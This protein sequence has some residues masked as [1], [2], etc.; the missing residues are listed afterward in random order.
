[1]EFYNTLK[2]LF[3]RWPSSIYRPLDQA[4]RQIR[5]LRILPASTADEVVSC[6]LKTVDFSPPLT[7]TRFYALS[8]VWGSPEAGKIILVD[9]LPLKVTANLWAMLWQLRHDPPQPTYGWPGKDEWLWADAICIN[10]NDIEER[11]Q[12]IKLFKDIYSN[13]TRV[14]AW[15]GLPDE[16]KIDV[17]LRST[18]FL[19][20]AIDV[21]DLD[22]LSEH[23]EYCQTD[24]GTQIGSNHY[25]EAIRAFADSDYWKRTWISQEVFLAGDRCL[26]FCGRE[27]LQHELLV[28]FA[29][30]LQRICERKGSRP[31]AFSPVVWD[32][33]TLAGRSFSWIDQYAT[34]QRTHDSKM[35]PGYP[36]DV[37]VWGR[38]SHDPRDAIYALLGIMDLDLV[39]DYAKSVADVYIDWHSRTWSSPGYSEIRFPPF[40]YLAGIGLLDD[41]RPHNI[42]SWIPN[43]SQLHR[44]ERLGVVM[45]AQFGPPFQFSRA[46]GLQAPSAPSKDTVF[47]CTGFSCGTVVS[48]SRTTDRQGS[49]APFSITGTLADMIYDC[50]VE[51][52]IHKFAR[53]ILRELTIPDHTDVRLSILGDE[54]RNHHPEFRRYID[55]PALANRLHESTLSVLHMG[56][57]LAE[58]LYENHWFELS[59]VHGGLNKLKYRAL[60]TTSNGFLGLGPKRLKV[61]DRLYVLDECKSLVLLRKIEKHWVLVGQCFAPDVTRERVKQMIEQGEVN[62]EALEIH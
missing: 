48:D 20:K 35:G 36:V 24:D 14:L 33:L 57:P 41:E 42:P 22:S 2:A 12:Q 60:F 56:C 62:F 32:S 55:S 50:L 31:P 25:W 58:E 7:S 54:L 8:Y 28:L 3:P 44:Q 30:K 11:N 26:F 27:S 43:L 61:G 5:L 18:K 9:G 45:K 52:G 34:V 59:Q 13:A 19:A 21:N 17:G 40:Y 29:L 47:S 39:V 10:Q 4:R 51:H 16:K 23:P 15:L 37:A 53:V 46:P 38:Q 6:T 49:Q 1:M